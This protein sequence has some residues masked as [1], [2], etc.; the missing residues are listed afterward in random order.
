MI[1]DIHTVGIRWLQLAQHR[2]PIR[3]THSGVFRVTNWRVACRGY[4][5]M[6][7]FYKCD[8]TCSIYT[9]TVECF[10]S[11]T[12]EWRAEA[13]MPSRRRCVCVCVCLCVCLCQKKKTLTSCCVSLLC[14]FCVCV[15][16]R[17]RVCV[18]VGGGGGG[19]VLSSGLTGCVFGGR[20]YALG[21]Y[22][23]KNF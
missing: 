5:R 15:C 19:G 22:D 14:L 6:C 3:Y 13:P 12:G 10:E 18:C 4:D 21:G 11:R 20:V 9:H 2:Y 23:G 1:I 8:R 16:V 17:V 7:S